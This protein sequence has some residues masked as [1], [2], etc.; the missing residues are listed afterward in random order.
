MDG[1]T[2]MSVHEGEASIREFYAT[3]FPSLLQL[4]SGITDVEEIKQTELC[5]L[6]FCRNNSLETGKIT[7][8]DVVSEH[9]C[10]ICMEVNSKVVLPNC[11]HSLCLKVLSGLVFASGAANLSHDLF[12]RIALKGVNPGDLWIITDDSEIIDLSI[13]SRENLL[14]PFSYI[15][16]LPLF[17]P[18]TAYVPYNY[19]VPRKQLY[20]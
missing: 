6:K 3:I 15:E 1:K 16:K 4:Q 20:N 7:E 19:R 9:E 2:T 17:V 5:S 13:I 12:G 14:M 11:S 18:D 8:A 10:E